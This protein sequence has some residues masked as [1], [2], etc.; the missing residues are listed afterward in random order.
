[1]RDEYITN[2]LFVLNN[3]FAER[4]GGHTLT[5]RYAEIIRPSK[6][7]PTDERTEEEVISSIQ[8]KLKALGKNERI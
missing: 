7:D 8:G 5:K 2:A 3:N 1:M 6:E 4:F